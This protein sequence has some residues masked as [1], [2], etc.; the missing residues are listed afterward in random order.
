MG[1]GGWL[2]SGTTQ[3]FIIHSV[4]FLDGLGNKQSDMQNLGDKQCIMSRNWKIE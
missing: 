4:C 1:N 3:S 2:F